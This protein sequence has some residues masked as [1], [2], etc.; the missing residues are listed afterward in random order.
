MDLGL[1][2]AR[3]LVTAGSKGIGLSC[4]RA[5]VAEGARVVISSRDAD[6]LESAEREIGAAGH[7][8]ADLHR[9]VDF[10]GC[11]EIV[12]GDDEAFH[13]SG[14]ETIMSSRVRR[15]WK[16]STPSRRRR[17]SMSRLVSISLTI[18]MIFDGRK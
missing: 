15:N 6:R 17:T 4:A 11:A 5:L 16:N 3:A 7:V 8:V 13:A 10:D 12:S 14:Y 1:D 18:S 9:V 2:G